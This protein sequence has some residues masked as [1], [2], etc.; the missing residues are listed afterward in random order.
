[1]NFFFP[2]ND[3]K[4]KPLHSNSTVKQEIQFLMKIS[5]INTLMDLKYERGGHKT[6]FVCVE[7]T[8]KA[9]VLIQK[10]IPQKEEYCI[11]HGFY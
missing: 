10:Q 3:N 8:L 6:Q 1:M 2:L 9:A 7:L 11:W 5:R 4:T